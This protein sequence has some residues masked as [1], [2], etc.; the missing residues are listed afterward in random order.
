[1]RV[2]AMSMRRGL[3][4]D[5]LRV[6]S[7]A[8]TPGPH[9]AIEYVY[10]LQVVPAHVHFPNCTLWSESFEAYLEYG[11]RLLSIPSI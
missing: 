11:V 9:N 7:V 5:R 2:T 3:D 10:L 1:M 8:T 6:V 4:I